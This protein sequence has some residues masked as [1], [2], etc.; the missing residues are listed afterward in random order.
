MADYSRDTGNEVERFELSEPPQYN[1]ELTRRDLLGVAGAGLVIMVHQAAAFGQSSGAKE[2]KVAARLHIAQDGKITVLTSKVD[3]GQ[4]SRA[5]ITQAAAEELRV[6]VDQIKLVMADTALT[7]DDGGTA[8]SRTTPST[9]PAVRKGAAAA[10]EILLDVAAR[11]WGVE[12]ASLKLENGVISEPSSARKLSY[13]ELARAKDLAKEFAQVVPADVSVAG[14]SEWKVLGTSVPRP[15]GREVVT[16][17]HK[18][19]SDIVRPNML[20]GKVLRPPS[21]GAT[22]KEIDLS[23]AEKMTGVVAVRDGN[24]AGC[25]APTS[26]RAGQAV[27]ALEKG[28]SW[29]TQP[30][31]SSKELFSYLKEHH[32]DRPASH[33]VRKER[34]IRRLHQPNECCARPMRLPTSNMLRWSPG[35]RW[36][37]GRTGVLPFG[38]ARS[39]RIVSDRSCPRLST[40]R[41]SMSA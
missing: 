5:Q 20:Y 30:H 36:P 32:R 17:A 7:P 21:Y 10:R 22:L 37:S 40:F 27:E 15:T 19:P 31:P 9:V 1:F 34:W 26:F 12:R 38:P 39:S 25:A 18:Y 14:V 4:G 6:A 3:V 29:Q 13:A 2:Q 16:G 24:F 11:Q 8:G 33:A 28:S 41:R 35:R 23:P